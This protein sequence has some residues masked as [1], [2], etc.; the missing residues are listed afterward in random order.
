MDISQGPKRSKMAF[1]SASS[2]LARASSKRSEGQKEDKE[3]KG[4]KFYLCCSTIEQTAIVAF[5][6]ILTFLAFFSL[7]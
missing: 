3:G 5:L 2:T 4:L 7:F 1:L 6:A